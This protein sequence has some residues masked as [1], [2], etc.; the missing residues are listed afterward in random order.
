MSSA[1]Y[2]AIAAFAVLVIVFVLKRKKTFHHV[3]NSKEEYKVP[4]SDD[5]QRVYYDAYEKEKQNKEHPQEEAK[6]EDHS[7]QH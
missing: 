7:E 2:V 4:L 5:I 3:Q 1:I 6:P